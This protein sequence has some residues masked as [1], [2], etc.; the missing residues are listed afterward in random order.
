MGELVAVKEDR[1]KRM[2][3]ITGAAGVGKSVVVGYIYRLAKQ[4]L[5]TYY[6]I[7]IIPLQSLFAEQNYNR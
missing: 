6:A 4:N 5:Q 2:V 7:G 1:A 3:W